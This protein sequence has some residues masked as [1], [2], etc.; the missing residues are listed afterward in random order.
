LSITGPSVIYHVRS[1]RTIE[2]I[3]LRP[4]DLGL[5]LAPLESIQG[6]TAEENAAITR[7]VLAGERG[8]RRDVVLL[9]AAAALYAA[10]MVENL[11][12]GVQIAAH[13]IDSGAAERKL[14]HLAEYSQNPVELGVQPQSSPEPKAEVAEPAAAGNG[15]AA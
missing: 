1:G 9:N 7:S 10:D 14:A 2:H 5:P 6:G 11:Y 3:S 12:E 15:K 4:Q 8:P 13:A